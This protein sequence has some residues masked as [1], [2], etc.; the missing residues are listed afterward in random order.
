M[1]KDFILLFALFC[2]FTNNQLHAQWCAVDSGLTDTYV[3]SLAVSGT[4]LFAG[5]GG[6]VFLST[7]NGTN[8]TAVD[9]GLTN[10]II[11]AFA[12]SGTNIFVGTRG[13]VFLS[14][15]NGTSWT[16][17]DSGL[18]E[19]NVNALA[20]STNGSGDTNIFVAIKSVAIGFGS[21]YLS[22]NNGTHWTGV[23]TGLDGSRSDC[24]YASD[25]NLFT[26]TED[27]LYLSTNNGTNWAAIDSGLTEPYGDEAYAFAGYDTY[28]FAGGY[29]GVF[30]STNNGTSWTAVDSGLT[31]TFVNALA[32]SGTNLFAGTASGGVFL[33]TNNG[34][35]WSAVNTSLANKVVTCF[36]ISGTNLFAGTYGGGVWR[37]SLSD[38]VTGVNN[39]KSGLPKE[40]SLHQNYPNPF[41]PATT[42][43]FYLPSKSFVSLKIFDLLGKEIATI[44]SEEMPAGSY[45]RQW[46]AAK[47]SSGIYFY[48]LQASAFIETK[49]LILLR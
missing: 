6:G 5:T 36:A 41:N 29:H 4:N 25:T 28:L 3:S 21:I 22:T 13:G 30:R 39:V 17:V 47:I 27:G 26:S 32:V 43:S 1:K 46:N 15:N 19:T 33:S 35:S 20:V 18:T 24:L 16:A 45:S 14:T 12:V 11:T 42:I 10:S 48:R 49:K 2:L 44:V 37:R 23:N 7:N 34:T 9:S 38:M 40:F 8:W 31:N